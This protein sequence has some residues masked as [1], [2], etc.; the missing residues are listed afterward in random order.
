M[1][2]LRYPGGH[3]VR[4]MFACLFVIMVVSGC[5]AG[6][7]VP[8][9]AA[10]TSD[11]TPV[12]PDVVEAQ[13]AASGPVGGPFEGSE[14]I[15]IP[16]VFAHVFG[17]YSVV[18]PDAPWLRWELESDAAPN[19]TSDA[20]LV[21]SVD[22]A[23]APSA[24]GPHGA[25]VSVRD[26]AGAERARIDV[27]LEVQGDV[28]LSGP[29]GGP[30]SGAVDHA[31]VAN[32]SPQPDLYTFATDKPWVVARAPDVTGPDFQLDLSIDAAMAPQKPGKHDAGI[33]VL[34]DGAPHATIRVELDVFGAFHAAGPVGGP[35][36]ASVDPVSVENRSPAAFNYRIGSTEPWIVSSA[37]ASGVLGVAEELPLGL[38]VDAELAPRSLGTHEAT[39][40][41]VDLDT[42]ENFATVRAVL[43]VDGEYDTSGPAGGPFVGTGG[44]YQIENTRSGAYDYAIACDQ[45]WVTWDVPTTGTLDAGA[46]MDFVV[47]I[48]PSTAP[49]VPGAHAAVLTIMDPGDQAVRA[50]LRVTLRIENEESSDAA[51]MTTANRTTGAAPF[52]VFFDAVDRTSPAWQSGVVQPA[53]GKF[54]SLHY[55]WDF[56]DAGAGTWRTSGKSRN[57]DTGFTAAHVFEKPGT[58]T[59]SLKVTDPE[60]NTE[61]HYAQSITVTALS[62]STYYVDATNG[63]DAN[64]GLTED[65]AWRTADR[66]LASGNETNAT[67]LFKRGE[68][69]STNRKFVITAAGPGLIGAY[70]TGAKPIITAS[71]TTGVIEIKASDWRVTH[72]DIRGPGS[73]DKSKAVGLHY[74]T[75]VDNT[76]MWQLDI[77]GFRSGIEWSNTFH[78]SNPPSGTVLGEIVTRETLVHGMFV[79]GQKIAVLGCDMQ[80]PMQQHVL[81]MF[82]GYKA[83]IGHSA[84]RDSGSAQHALKLHGVEHSSSNLETQFVTIMDNR[85]RG[86]GAWAVAIGPQNGQRDERLR[87]IVIERN[88]SEPASRVQVDLL[89]WASDVTVRNNVFVATGSR[90]Y[91]TAVFVSKRGAEPLARRV[92]VLH[93]TMI[94]QDA[95]AEFFM[96]RLGAC[97]DVNVRNNLGSAPLASTKKVIHGTCD[98]LVSSPNLLTDTPAFQDPGKGDFRLAATSDALDKAVVVPQVVQDYSGGKRAS[99]TAPDLGAFER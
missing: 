26:A 35:F 74:N 15:R 86:G 63:D 37:P 48:D 75:R 55:E 7:A 25:A 90:T 32:P 51:A 27:S 21:L 1:S 88:R 96:A 16:D 22:P 79:G 8:V 49:T 64:D 39:V 5:G 34:A 95:A 14:P 70:G 29:A 66:A 23:E 44:P 65:K 56:G 73:S 81:R 60:A 30:F 50:L 19:D 89:I 67:I 13:F 80:G 58:Y 94:R 42:A 93:N 52:A 6:E 71:N 4:L 9:V 62:G 24:V 53:D 59:V 12:V 54:G 91:Y 87:H 2:Q 84:L 41:V 36:P 68:T 17:T 40:T 57:L 20:L 45:S 61:H 28:R 76:L 98:N 31:R 83:V 82:Q 33:T 3:G 43:Q 77:R 92:D 78:E 18:A 11:A 99:G 38:S 46:A 69:F 97:S 72:L 85:F 10:E 47:S